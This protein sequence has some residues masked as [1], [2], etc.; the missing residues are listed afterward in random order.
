M[1][2]KKA[3]EGSVIKKLGNKVASSMSMAV[4]TMRSFGFSGSITVSGMLMG[5]SV[6][7]GVE[8]E[9]EEGEGEVEAPAG[10]NEADAEDDDDEIEAIEANG[11][12][13]KSTRDEAEDEEVDPTTADSPQK[14]SKF[15][16]TIKAGMRGAMKRVKVMAFE[17]KKYSLTGTV[18]VGVDATMF[19]TG[20]TIDFEVSLSSCLSE[21]E[22]KEMQEHE[23]ERSK[24]RQSKKDAKRLS[25][26][27]RA[28]S[29]I[30]AGSDE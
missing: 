7:M 5:L 20:I 1:E 16:R 22:F 19:G 12:T 21:V 13:V 15:K 2:S 11:S 25:V 4:M 27:R 10:D 30:P 9:A 6:S 23:K 18:G 3:I 8:V 26:S 28:D 24:A 29:S 17:M 14:E